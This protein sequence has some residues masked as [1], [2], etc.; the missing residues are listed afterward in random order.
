MQMKSKDLNKNKNNVAL[1]FLEFESFRT[2]FMKK[3]CAKSK[4][5]ENRKNGDIRPVVLLRSEEQLN[6]LMIDITKDRR[7]LA[8]LTAEPDRFSPKATKFR[9]IS[10]PLM[11]VEKVSISQPTATNS[12]TKTK[13]EVLRSLGRLVDRLEHTVLT[14][15]TQHS[16]DALALATKE[17]KAI[18]DD[19]EEIY[20]VRTYGYTDTAV[21]LVQYGIVQDKQRIPMTG[22]FAVDFKGVCQVHTQEKKDDKNAI[23]AYPV[24]PISCSAILKGMLYRQSDVDAYNSRQK[25]KTS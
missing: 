14:T 11:G 10:D 16:I 8:I 17:Y 9:P 21:Y 5:K 3:W 24:T 6:E 23:K 20:R 25:K 4:F 13:S 22:L 19:N 15:G 1:A 2:E 18:E 12:R 7:L